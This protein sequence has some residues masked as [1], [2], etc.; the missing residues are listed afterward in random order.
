V[1]ETAF[2]GPRIGFGAA[3]SDRIAP[4]DRD[5]VARAVRD[6]VPGRPTLVR[7][8]DLGDAIPADLAEG[9]RGAAVSI[10][11][12]EE[13]EGLAEACAALGAKAS[14]PHR[15]DLLLAVLD[16]L[17]GRPDSMLLW[18]GVTVREV[19][20]VQLLG[21]QAGRA[22]IVLV[23]PWP[24]GAFTGFAIL[25]GGRPRQDVGMP[26]ADE[27]TRVEELTDSAGA[28]RE[29]LEEAER[30]RRDAGL[31]A[32]QRGRLEAACYWAAARLGEYDEAEACLRRLEE[33][34]AFE[35][36]FLRANLVRRRGRHAEARSLLSQALS[37]AQSA[38]DRARVQIELGDLAA[39]VDDAVLADRLF[40]QGIS[41]LSSVEDGAKDPRWRTALGRG[42]RDWGH[43]LASRSDRADEA[44]SLLRRALAVNALDGRLSQ[45]GAA[46]SSRGVFEGSRGRWDEAEE[47]IAT[48]ASVATWSNNLLAWALAV[49]EM[50][51]MA[52]T[53]GRLDLALALATGALGRLRGEERKYL[54]AVGR[55]WLLAAQVHWRKGAL[56]AAHEAARSALQHLPP[57]RTR[58]CQAA[59]GIAELCGALAPP[60][61]PAPKAA[62]RSARLTSPSVRRR[63]AH[64]QRK[65]RG[66]G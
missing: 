7:S 64:L 34:D 50:A 46:L 6:A 2:N 26:G 55:L 41:S 65:G 5:L 42:L 54:T 21:P 12:G 39:A 59:S 61:P 37:A 35:G 20:A 66:R 14:S 27:V 60:A 30:L 11:A 1:G 53:A 57:D 48:A 22:R 52:L 63:S 24:L 47:A 49:R 15:G 40:A 17:A 32:E 43:L 18:T 16:A 44:A 10:R 36:L 31:P 4:A 28:H 62:R 8:L 9:C 56:A 13:P 29:A 58:D 45:V 23:S 3:G 51:E 38:R 33:R 25:D 19:W